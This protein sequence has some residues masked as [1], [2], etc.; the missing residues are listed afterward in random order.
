MA[1]SCCVRTPWSEILMTSLHNNKKPSFP[2]TLDANLYACS[3]DPWFD[4]YFSLNKPVS[5]FQCYIL[6][7]IRVY[8]T[9]VQ[10][11][12]CIDQ[13]HLFWTVSKSN[14]HIVETC[15]TTPYTHKHDV[16]LTH[17]NMTSHSSVLV[18]AL[19]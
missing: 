7:V 19:Q 17:I 1:V 14:R 16:T 4:W 6:N 8:V 10:H 3:R 13:L 18:Q 5:S 2:P 9:L 11:Y 12:Q 15:K